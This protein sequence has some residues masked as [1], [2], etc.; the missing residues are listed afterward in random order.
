[1]H[2]LDNLK[3]IKKL[4]PANVLASIQ[5]LP[6]QIEDGWQQAQQLKVP[7]RFKPQQIIING[8]GGSGLPAHF[9][10]AVFSDKIKVPLTTL[11]SYELPGWIDDKTL[12]IIQSYS[13]NTEEPLS[14]IG[15]AQKKRAKITA[16]TTDGKLGKLIQNKK[17]NGV[18]FNPQYNLCGQ[19][20]IGLGYAVSVLLA[21]LSK[22]RLIKLNF[23]Q[24]KKIIAHLANEQTELDVKNTEKSNPAKLAAQ[25]LNGTIPYIVAADFLA[26][27]AHIFANQINESA[28]SLADYFIISEMNHHLIEGLSFPKNELGKITFFFFE[29]AL[30]HPRNIQ[31]IKITKHILQK[32]KINYLSYRLQGG[33][34]LSQAFEAIAVSSYISYYMAVL[35][36]VNPA[37]TPWVN[38]LKAKLK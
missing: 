6:E 24:F 5:L 29:S 26:A 30:Y 21:V 15:A 27:N 32:K 2:I 7:I 22:Y 16:I 36:K 34:K 3:Q 1:M 38:Y 14:T 33:D 18:I 31:R 20:R 37:E 10:R 25:H 23:K 28:K 13:G 4:D 9:V 35:N 17:M 11:N 12:Y 19:A 8:M